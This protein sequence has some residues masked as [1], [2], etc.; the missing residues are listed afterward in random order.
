MLS[1]RTRDGATCFIGA[2]W[3]HTFVLQSRDGTA[4]IHVG[5]DAE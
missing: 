2:V 4:G 3:G 1:V 5:P